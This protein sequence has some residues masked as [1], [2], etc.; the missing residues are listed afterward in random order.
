MWQ[1]KTFGLGVLSALVVGVFA[2][3]A[4]GAQPSADRPVLR[5]ERS[6]PLPDLSG[7]IDH[8]VFD[9]QRTSLAIG[10]VG[11]GALEV[12]NLGTGQVRRVARLAEP[13]G[14]AYLP[15]EDQY[16]VASGGDGT[17]RFYAAADLAPVGVVQL[18]G[19]ADNLRY[20]PMTDRLIAADGKGFAN[21]DPKARSVVSRIDVG[22]HPEG[23]QVDPTGTALVANVP[24]QRR[25]VRID[26]KAGAV[27][28]SWPQTA[29]MNFPMA[30]S[31][32][33]RTGASVFRMP[34]QLLA[35]D[36]TTGQTLARVSACGDADDAFF[37]AKRSRLYV[38]CGAGVVRAYDAAKGF[39][40]V[41]EAKS[42]AGARTALF[43]PEI[44]RL[45]VAARAEA[46]QPA[47]LL[48]FAP[49]P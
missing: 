16:V 4:C 17:V 42:R 38:V 48:V 36:A 21:I 29:I 8:L 49:E 33:G 35:F 32:D 41:G 18:G 31:A 43:V 15:A 46:G 45:I 39:A 26:L 14:V 13:Q 7:R 1:V 23:F 28:A 2:Y 22:A 10:G 24:D 34:S 3:R 44:D 12:V 11:A 47:A 5:L 25:I 40:A 6:I 20:V 27:E 9:P 37:D 19:D 30:L